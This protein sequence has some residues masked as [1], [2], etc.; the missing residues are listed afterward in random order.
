M[1]TTDTRWEV[2]EHLDF[3]VR[4]ECASKNCEHE[5]E[6]VVLVTPG[7][8]SHPHDKWYPACPEH[9]VHLASGNA[10]CVAC[11]QQIALVAIRNL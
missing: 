10:K 11:A 8:A 5:A 9:A 7:P 4:V 3:Q 1:S 2:I 6:H